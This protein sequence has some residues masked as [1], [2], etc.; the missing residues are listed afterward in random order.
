MLSQAASVQALARNKP[1]QEETTATVRKFSC[2]TDALGVAD[3]ETSN[4]HPGAEGV[5]FGRCRG[6][7][8]A[9]PNLISMHQHSSLLFL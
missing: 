6:P 3:R 8:C 5:V 4:T 9:F 7:E 2:V 1:E